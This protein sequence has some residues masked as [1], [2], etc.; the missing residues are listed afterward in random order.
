MKIAIDVSQIIYGTGVSVY[1]KELISHLLKAFPKN[2]YTL[3]GGSLRRISE[4]RDFTANFNA[5]QV[6]FPIPPFAADLLWNKLHIVPIETLIGKMDVFHSSDWAEPP[7]SCFKV[8]T[9]HDLSPLVLP[10]YTPPKIVEVH[11]RKFEWVKRE[12]DRVIVP[13]N[14]TKDEAVKLGIDPENVRVIGEALQ[15]GFR[16][17]TQFEVERV[18]KLYGIKGNYALSVGTN[19]RKNTPR[20]VQAFKRVRSDKLPNLAIVGGGKNTSHD[21]IRYLGQVSQTSLAALYSG[22]SLLI[23]TSLSEGFGLPILEA[24]SCGCPVL[25][26]NISSMP[27]VAGDAALLVNPLSVNEIAGGI[28]KTLKASEKLRVKGKSRVKR[29]NWEDIAARTMEVY[30]ES[31]GKSKI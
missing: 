19:P 20:I 7:A 12:V 11:K 18:K 9:I 31:T 30:K 26:S 14:A 28:V 27:E 16:K 13:S 15:S 10:E 25:T 3:F 8:T 21:G 17:A 24:F 6:I 4:L 29:Y 22:A 1:T 5:K 23:Y 2:Q